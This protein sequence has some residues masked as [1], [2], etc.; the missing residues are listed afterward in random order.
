MQQVLLKRLGLGDGL[1][2]VIA[3]FLAVGRIGIP[4][5]F[6]EE[7]ILPFIVQPR[8]NFKLFPEIHGLMV[9]QFRIDFFH[10][11]LGGIGG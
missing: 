7:V 11:D 10:L 4:L 3:F 2:E 1:V 6:L 9:F 5:P 8:Q